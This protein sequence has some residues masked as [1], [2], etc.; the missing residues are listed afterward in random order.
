MPKYKAYGK[1]NAA[2]FIGE[3]EA[4]SSEEA[5]EKAEADPIADW[6]VYLCH[7]CS[8]EIEADEVYEIYVEEF[9][10]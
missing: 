4:D 5:K 10:D 3:Y 6:G 9:K 1:I 7:H 2:K 8:K